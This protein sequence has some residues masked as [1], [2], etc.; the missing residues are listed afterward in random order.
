[1]FEK[2]IKRQIKLKVNLLECLECL[3]EKESENLG[4][5]K[6]L[7]KSIEG[8]QETAKEKKERNEFVS[9]MDEV[10]KSLEK[11]EAFQKAKKLFGIDSDEVVKSSGFSIDPQKL[12]KKDK[13]EFKKAME[14]IEE[15]ARKI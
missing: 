1:M 8:P 5:L 12:N 6:E 3:Y 2:E 9:L 7:L 10:E 13:A 4:E 14:V 15:L 11:N